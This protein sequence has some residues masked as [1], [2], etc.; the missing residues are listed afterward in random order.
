[1]EADPLAELND[2]IA[3]PLAGYWP[4]SL[5]ATL[6]M[7]VS[8]VIIA[9]A[10]LHGW[11]IHRHRRPLR[12]ALNELEKLPQQVE[13]ATLSS[14]IKR[15]ALAYY[16]REEVASLTGDEWDLWLSRHQSREQQTSWQAL[17]SR[18]YTQD[19]RTERQLYHPL[20]RHTLTGLSRGRRPC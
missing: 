18:Q 7:V 17:S 12:Q 3:T 16:P 11:R 19:N 8:M 10:L 9:G 14:L 2:I 20:V 15:C 4:L 13:I 6:L 1:M 5:S